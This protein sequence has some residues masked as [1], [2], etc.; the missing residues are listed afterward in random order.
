MGSK[1]LP[2]KTEKLVLNIDHLDEEVINFIHVGFN[3][4]QHISFLHI[5]TSSAKEIK[6]GNIDNLSKSEQRYIKKYE[7]A[8]MKAKLVTSTP[9]G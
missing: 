6:W 2:D 7:S 3:S 5:V 9:P 4:N 1:H 8:F